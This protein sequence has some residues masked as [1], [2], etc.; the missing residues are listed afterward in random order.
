[1][2]GAR[3]SKEL[4]EGSAGGREGDSNGKLTSGE[5]ANNRS[6]GGD[7]H[8]SH[9]ADSSAKGAEGS[10][11]TQMKAEYIPPREDV[12][13]QNKAPDDVYVIVS[14]EVEIIYSEEERGK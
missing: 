8:G 11:V 7:R 14:G 9:R 2:V 13:M 5:R 3:S 12:I 4:L 1:M 6:S 10:P